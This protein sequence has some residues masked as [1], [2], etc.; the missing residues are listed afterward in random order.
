MK[1]I[2]NLFYVLAA[3]LTLAS[4]SDDMDYTPAP[5]ENGP[6]VYFSSDAED[7][8]KIAVDATSVT[9]PVYRMN[10]GEQLTVNIDNTQPAGNL[11]TIPASVTFAEGSDK[12]EV[13]ITFDFAEIEADEEY[14]ITLAISDSDATTQYGAE[15]YTFAICYPAPYKSLG[16]CTFTDNIIAGY[17][18]IPVTTWQCEIEENEMTA[19]LFRLKNVFTSY[20]PYFKEGTFAG[21]P[22]IYLYINATDP[23][24]VIMPQQELGLD[25]GDGMFSVTAAAYGTYKDG[26]I[27]WPVKGLA[28]SEAEYKE[29]AFFYTNGSGATRVV[30]PGVVLLNPEVELEG[31]G[32]FV[33]NEGAA[34]YIVNVTPNE[35]AEGYKF[36]VVSGSIEF[37]EDA[38][39]ATAAG[40]ID[41]SV[42]ST[43][44]KLSG[45]V[46][47]VKVPVEADGKYTVVFVPFG[48]NEGNAVY[49]NAAA[50]N[51]AVAVGGGE[52][53]PDP[54]VDEYLGT[55]TLHCMNPA[56]EEGADD[57]AI[58]WGG[59]SIEENTNETMV[60]AGYNVVVYGLLPYNYSGTNDGVPGTYDRASHTILLESFY[61]FGDATLS[62]SVGTARIV[63]RALAWEASQFTDE[64]RLKL[65]RETGVISFVKSFTESTAPAST[66]GY[67]LYCVD[68]TNPSSAFGNLDFFYDVTLVPAE[69]E[70]AS[71]KKMSRVATRPERV[72]IS[73]NSLLRKVQ[74]K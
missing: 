42:D 62:L 2:K 14:E 6:A 51:F 71:V 54:D 35:D 52:V 25:L 5:K 47:S 24:K 45:D 43:E 70:T 26:I 33:D 34:S 28:V 60:A 49:G 59:V 30:M 67:A 12:A 48:I 74:L 9:I 4:C 57:S 63:F 29:G 13:K 53:E 44:G 32:T 16:M 21:W 15:V 18:T 66:N 55:Y 22:D 50:L 8:I 7:V 19:G 40:I 36:A 23:D 1:L 37:D 27:S 69:P 11:F 72:R 73:D 68:A 56:S 31:V 17:Y 58:Y 3:T 41:G 38:V 46:A 39:A 65:D 10:A 20:C 64:V 61:Y